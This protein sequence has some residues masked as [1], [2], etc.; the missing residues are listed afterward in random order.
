MHI[1]NINESIDAIAEVTNLR[2]SEK[3][4]YSG[5]RGCCRIKEDYLTSTVITSLEG[6]TIPY[7]ATHKSTVA[8]I[9]P[10]VYPK[11][12]WPGKVIEIYEGERI[13]GSMKII[14]VENKL[15]E[16][17]FEKD[18]Q[19]TDNTPLITNHFSY[20]PEAGQN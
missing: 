5:Y 7:G 14:S 17:K 1:R 13:V 12:L 4:F 19:E 20:K 6:E 10:E 3:P 9:T 18:L 11:S 8:F 15:L 2:E 16:N